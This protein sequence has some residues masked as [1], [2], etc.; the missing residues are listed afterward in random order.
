MNG[1]FDMVAYTNR[2]LAAAA[3]GQTGV[4]PVRVLAC[5][6]CGGSGWVETGMRDQMGIGHRCYHCSGSGRVATNG[7]E[8]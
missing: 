7:G 3:R 5:Q 6:M 1:T 4:A 2:L 8:P